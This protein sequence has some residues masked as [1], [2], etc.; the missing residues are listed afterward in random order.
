[1]LM[2][3]LESLVSKIQAGVVLN[4][5]RHGYDVNQMKS[6]AIFI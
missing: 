5:E 1:M 6:E 3:C 2:Q 4:F